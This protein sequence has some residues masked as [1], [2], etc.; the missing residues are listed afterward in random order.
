LPAELAI[1]LDKYNDRLREFQADTDSAKKNLAG[2]G[3]RKATADLDTAKLAAY[4]APCSLIF[5]LD[6]SISTS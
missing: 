6:E 2:G 4:A 5:N 3:Q 1:I